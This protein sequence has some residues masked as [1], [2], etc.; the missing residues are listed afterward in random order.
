M[1]IRHGSRRRWTTVDREAINDASLSFRA[2]GVLV[3]LLDKPD[4]WEVRSSAIADV[5][6][7]GRDAIRTALTELEDRG[8]LVREKRQTQGGHWITETWVYEQPSEMR[9]DR[10]LENRE[11]EGQALT[12]SLLKTNTE[13]RSS[14][15]KPK[16][17]IPEPFIVTD[18]MVAWVQREYPTLDYDA[19]T[20]EWVTWAKADDKRFA[21][22]S[23][24]WRNGMHRAARWHVKSG[25]ARTH[26]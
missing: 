23:H 3:W 21:D 2:R 19:A 15:R 24:A 20:R 10:S 25:P 7:E 17:P 4:N 12:T 11:S 16:V 6:K 9:I 5:G 13:A 22:W 18:D 1:I 8:Y 14:R 26:L